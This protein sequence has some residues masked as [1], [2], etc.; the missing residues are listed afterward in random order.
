M[1]TPETHA[2]QAVRSNP[3]L[4]VG[5]TLLGDFGSNVLLGEVIAVD[6]RHTAIKWGRLEIVT[7]DNADDLA[8]RRVMRFRPATSWWRRLFTANDSV[9]GRKHARKGES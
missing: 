5:D 9:E 6:E 7:I 2:G 1:T 3:L 8:R 4:A